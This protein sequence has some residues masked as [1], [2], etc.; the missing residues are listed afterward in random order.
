MIIKLRLQFLLTFP[1]NLQTV[2]KQLLQNE[3]FWYFIVINVFCAELQRKIDKTSVLKA[4]SDKI[5]TLGRKYAAV[6][7]YFP[8]GI[9]QFCAFSA[10]LHIKII[11]E[12][13]LS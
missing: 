4:L 6:E 5:V 10:E 8:L 9:L 11:T 2:S 13:G 3:R 12:C 1:N 7:H